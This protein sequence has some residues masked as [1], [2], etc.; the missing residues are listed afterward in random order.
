ML[1]QYPHNNLKKLIVITEGDK[2]PEVKSVAPQTL[3]E[4]G[5]HH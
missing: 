1:L 2:S 3:I 5:H 4:S